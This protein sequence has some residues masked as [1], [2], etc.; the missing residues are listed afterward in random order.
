MEVVDSPGLQRVLEVITD[1]I[2][3]YNYTKVP[4]SNRAIS[5]L[6]AHLMA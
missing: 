5:F 1:Y 2:I 3:T 4:E 6:N